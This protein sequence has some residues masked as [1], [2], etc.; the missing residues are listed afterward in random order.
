MAL[1]EGFSLAFL[2]PLKAASR[3]AVEVLMQTHLLKGSVAKM[4]KQAPRQPANTTGLVS[5]GSVWVKAGPE[6]ASLSH[7]E[8]IKTPSI[9]ARIKDMARMLVAG[10]YPVLLQGVRADSLQCFV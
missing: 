2:M 8:F 7:R 5:I 9:E 10:K 4:L 6:N 3:S 1:Y